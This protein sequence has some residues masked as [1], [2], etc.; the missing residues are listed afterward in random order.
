MKVGEDNEAELEARRPDEAEQVSGHTAALQRQHAIAGL[1]KRQQERLARTAAAAQRLEAEIASLERNPVD[2]HFV[3]P[4]TLIE[5]YDTG[6]K[7]S[8]GRLEG[9]VI[10]GMACRGLF[11][12]QVRL[13]DNELSWA[14]DFEQNLDADGLEMDAR[15]DL[16]WWEWHGSGDSTWYR[17]DPEGSLTFTG[18]VGTFRQLEEHERKYLLMLY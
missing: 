4:I 17:D 7:S 2:A 15:T 5:S 6:Y 3:A 16:E 18:V 8:A 12:A 10:R 1:T 14:W 13:Y 9:R 11:E